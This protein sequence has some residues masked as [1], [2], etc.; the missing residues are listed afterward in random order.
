MHCRQKE[1]KELRNSKRRRWFQKAMRNLA[2]LCPE[3]PVRN[4]ERVGMENVDESWILKGSGCSSI[5]SGLHPTN[6]CGRQNNS[7]PKPFTCYS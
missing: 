1:A 5:Q 7:F 3:M 4:S 6:Q 2:W